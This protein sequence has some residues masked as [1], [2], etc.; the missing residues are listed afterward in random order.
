[1]VKSR[2]KIRQQVNKFVDFALLLFN[3]TLE[4][5]KKDQQLRDGSF[6][7]FMEINFYAIALVSFSGF[8]ISHI[9]SKTWLYKNLL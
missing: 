7:N 1:M 4:S 9:Y 8:C 5:E 2:N 6:K 3:Q